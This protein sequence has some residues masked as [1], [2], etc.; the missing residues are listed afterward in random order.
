MVQINFVPTVLPKGI[1]R[2]F[3]YNII[4]ITTTI[5]KNAVRVSSHG[6][7]LNG[8]LEWYFIVSHSH[9]IPHVQPADDVRPSHDGRPSNEVTPHPPGM[10]E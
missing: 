8:Y 9:I 2:W 10:T 7:C 6:Q 5:I 4:N 1:D 3:R